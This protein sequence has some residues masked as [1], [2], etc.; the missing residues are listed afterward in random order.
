MARFNHPI[1]LIQ[2][3]EPNFPDGLSQVFILLGKEHAKQISLRAS[4]MVQSGKLH[5]LH[6]S[7]PTASQE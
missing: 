5:P 4:L 7:N 3:E 6:Q 1:R 2:D